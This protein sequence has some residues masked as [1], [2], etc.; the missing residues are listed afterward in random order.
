M[1]NFVQKGDTITAVAPAGGV[2]S[3]QFVIVGSIGGVA[4]Y[5]AAAGANVELSVEG[6]FDL[7]K[8]TGD[9]LTA[10]SVA[11][12]TP[13]TGVVG[14]A[15]TTSIGWVLT[16]AGAGTTVARVRLVPCLASGATLLAEEPRHKKN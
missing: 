9:A 1:K 13:A 15:G 6:C 8:V 4:N 11:K 10:G 16:A 5:D 3:G 7:P 2:V 12:V 14:L